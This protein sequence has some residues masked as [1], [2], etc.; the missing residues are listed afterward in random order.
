MTHRNVLSG[1]A[2]GRLPRARTSWP[3][4]SLAGL[5]VASA[6]TIVLGACAAPG[7]GPNQATLAGS[8]TDEE[9][10]TPGSGADEPQIDPG[11]R[12]GKT[13]SGGPPWDAEATEACEAV[14]GDGFTQVAQSPDDA[15]TTTFWTKGGQWVV[16]DVAV[17]AQ[18]VEPAVLE[19][20]RRGRTGFDKRSLAVTTTVLPR[21]DGSPAAVRLV[22]GGRLPWRVDEIA[23]TFPDG[24]TEQATFV[25]SEDDPEEVWWSVAHTPTEGVLVDPETD[26]AALDP[27]TIAIVGAA[28]EAFRLPWEDLQRSE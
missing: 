16:C 5:A 14:V 13:A 27:V 19:S 4:R 15:G 10:A 23:Y 7:S 20:T 21:P 28:A 18:G 9:S 2:G 11:P 3:R 1:D 25:T 17:G 8:A 22:A 24:H 12:D 26:P 6:V